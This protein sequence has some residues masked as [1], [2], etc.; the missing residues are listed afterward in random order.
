MEGNNTKHLVTKLSRLF[1]SFP[2]GKGC[3]FLLFII[4]CSLFIKGQDIHFT[5]YNFS[6]LNENPAYTNLFDGD[7]RFVGNFKNQWQS[8]PVSYNTASASM[9]MN[10]VT[11][12][13]HDR[14]GG[15]L[16]FYYDR[17]G[18]SHLSSLNAALSFS[19]QLNFGKNDV[20]TIS[21]GYQIG[22]VNRSFD[23]TK[24]FFDNQFNGDAFNLSIPMK[25]SA[26]PILYF[27]TWASAWLINGIK[28]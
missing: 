9:D 5:Q 20:N 18:D 16:L 8:V 6:P 7:M 4:H 13:N 21:F 19:Y 10:F 11:L 17:A 28:G 23:Y 22:F 2:L 12:K 25:H 15:G 27:S 14:I 1:F 26:K 3:M 24:L